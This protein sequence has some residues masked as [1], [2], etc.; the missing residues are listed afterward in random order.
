MV[1]TQKNKNRLVE[2][3]TKGCRQMVSNVTGSGPFPLKRCRS[4]FE[5]NMEQRYCTPK[6]KKEVKKRAPKCDESD[7]AFFNR[8][9]RISC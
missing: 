4:C 8:L 9:L 2:C 7:E 6:K 1:S 5:K 3:A